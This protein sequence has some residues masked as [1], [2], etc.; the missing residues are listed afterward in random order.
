MIPRFSVVIPTYQRRALVVASVEAL[1]R[2]A[3]DQPFE[4]I[5]AVDGSTDGTAAAL[6]GLS[7]PISLTVLEQPNRGA[8]AARNLGAS[9]AK[10]EILLFLDDDME[11]DARLL[12]CHD[13][14]HRSGADV[15]FGHLPLHPAAPANFLSQGI[16]SWTD[17]RLARLTAP[18][19]EL[20][21]HDLMTGQMSLARGLFE[22]VGRFDGAFTRDGTF[23]DEDIDFGYR[24][25][26]DG[27]RLVF[28][29]AA[30]SYQNYVVTP[31]HYLQQWREAGRADVAFARKHPERSAAIFALNGA[32]KRANR[33]L[34]RPL[35]AL[36]PFTAPLMSLLRRIALHLVRSGQ[37][38]DRRIRFFYQIW[39]MQYWRGVSEAGGIPPRRPVRVLAYHAIQDLKDAPVIAPYCVPPSQFR[40]QVRLLKLAGFSF[41][42]GVAFTEYLRRG[43]PLP[44]RPILLTFDDAYDDL[45]EVAPF[46]AAHR[47]PAVVFTVSRTVGGV[48]AWDVAIGAPALPLLDAAGLAAVHRQGV[49][50]GAHSRTHRPLSTL[51]LVEVTDEIAGSVDDLDTLCGR[52]PRLFAYPEGDFDDRAKAAARSAGLEAA[53]AVNAG[54]ARCGDDPYEVPRIEILRADTG[55][56]FLWKVLRGG[57]WNRS[58]SSASGG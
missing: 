27:H 56:G 23:G 46:L 25:M 50:I 4:V 34:W 31:R 51:A 15:V 43:R 45:L 5:V 17:G 53:F 38:S 39:A 22:K 16:G 1:A 32:G 13:E 52:R 42:D 44:R 29:P 3:F 47:V 14:S 33:M 40:R 48:N 57:R 9:A 54:V 28:N 6:R 41:V 8:S 18:G 24:L 49:E 12:A 30:I 10:G 58:L 36:L 55:L 37:P 35:A 21:L 7:V 2:Q 19:A 11:A 26:R 20:T